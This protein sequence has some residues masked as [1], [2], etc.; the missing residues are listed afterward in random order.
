MLKLGHVIGHV[1]MGILEMEVA[2]CKLKTTHG[3][4]EAGILAMQPVEVE[5]KL[6]L[7][8]VVAISDMSSIIGNV[9]ALC[10]QQVSHAILRH[11]TQLPSIGKSETGELVKI[12]SKIVRFFVSEMMELLWQIQTVIVVQSQQQA[13]AV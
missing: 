6:V 3:I 13:K 8:S 9:L 12:M 7:S 4:Q 5:P 1:I 10:R 2:V 11:V